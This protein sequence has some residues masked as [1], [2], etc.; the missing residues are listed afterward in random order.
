MLGLNILTGY[1]GQISIGQ[2]AFMAVGAFSSAFL[3]TELG[4]SF[5]LALPC[6]A[7]IAG[8]V[9]ALFGLPA[10]RVKELYL[11]VST[12]AAQFI[13]LYVIYHLPWFGKDE[14]MSL[15]A[16]SLGVLT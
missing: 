6:A 16:Q 9:S 7:I 12:L 13:I 5:W 3:T 1:G 10:L 15:P 8:L 4:L 14:G 2:A 11:A